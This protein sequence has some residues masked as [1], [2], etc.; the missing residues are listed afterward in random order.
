VISFR[1]E[2]AERGVAM[3][4]GLGLDGELD[5]ASDPFFG[6]HGRMLAASQKEQ[7]LKVELLVSIAGPEPTAVASFNIHRDHF[8]GLYGLELADGGEAHTACIA[9]G[10]ERITLA[11]LRVHGVD[12]DA[13][14]SAIRRKLWP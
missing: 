6:R 12:L 3:L 5:A 1:D 4:G 7:A 11:L 2:W 9:F 14:P 10:N 13:W 8:T